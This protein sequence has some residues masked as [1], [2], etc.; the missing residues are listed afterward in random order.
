MAL[1]AIEQNYNFLNLTGGARRIGAIEQPRTWA[2][3][4]GEANPAET[5][6][7]N[8]ENKHGISNQTLVLPGRGNTVAARNLDLLG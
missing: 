5:G 7:V 6:I 4:G 1:S 2:V 3:G 8:L